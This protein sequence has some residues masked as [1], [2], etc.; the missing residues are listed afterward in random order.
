MRQAVTVTKP[1]SAESFVVRHE[2]VTV[3]RFHDTGI[4]TLADVLSSCQ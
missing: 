2:D 3:R 4:V 1:V